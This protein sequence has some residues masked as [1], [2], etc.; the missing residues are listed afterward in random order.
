MK[1]IS[2]TP[3][4]Y[5]HIPFCDTKCGYCDFYSITNNSLRPTFL[6]AIIKEINHYNIE[7]FISAKYDTI[8]LGGGT[9]SLLTPKE[10][11]SIFSTL[12]KTFPVSDDCE[13]TVEIN[14]GTIDND[15]LAFYKSIGI[16][17]LSIGVQ[18]FND[19]E[20][21]VLGRI[22]NSKQAIKTFESARNSGFNNISIDL[23]YALPNQ[24]MEKWKTSLNTGLSLEPDHVSAYN[25]IYEEGTPFYKKLIKGQL[26][27][28]SEDAES[29]F[30][31]QTLNTFEANSYKPYEV[32]SYA[33]EENKYSRHNYK[34]WIHS[35]Y[36]SF[37]PSAHSY[38]NKK[39]WSNIRSIGKY[40]ENIMH[41][42]SVI[43]F[44]ENLKKE[45]L[46]FENIMLSL[47]TF[48]GINFEIF[49]EQHKE[50]FIQKHKGLNEDLL[51]NGFALI[52]N[53]KF[54]LTRK[55]MLV[56]DEILSNF[57]PN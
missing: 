17:R 41:E 33:K 57:A 30:F 55:G 22:H 50:S 31:L 39:R 48:E 20:L 29:E 53:G 13:I 36:L 5:L 38:W 43:D 9:P 49:Q 52:E 8:Y 47:R 54:K 14:P 21:K 42:R 37:G 16:N 32:S 12:Y 19:D 23:I 28:Q 6:P 3:G 56:C 35:N 44:C 46:M 51:K 26:V 2:S 15:K 4:L 34:Y 7:P 25:L 24:K 27:K 11:E 1:N 45:T 10:M 40:I 18:S